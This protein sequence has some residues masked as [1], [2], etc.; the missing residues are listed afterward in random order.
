MQSTVSHTQIMGRLANCMTGYAI[1][2]AMRREFGFRTHLDG[3]VLDL[4][5]M[6]FRNTYSVP[7]VQQLC[8]QDFNWTQYARAPQLLAKDPVLSRGASIDYVQNVSVLR[9]Y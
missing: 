7:R 3:G 2:L 1:M 6:F 9:I 5:Q 8:H 4:L